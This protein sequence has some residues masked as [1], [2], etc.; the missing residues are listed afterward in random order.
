LTRELLFRSQEGEAVK[1]LRLRKRLAQSPAK[2]R[3]GITGRQ[4]GW[5]EGDNGG[6][7]TRPVENKG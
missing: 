7:F 5:R 2:K 3:R 1:F 6:S 4:M